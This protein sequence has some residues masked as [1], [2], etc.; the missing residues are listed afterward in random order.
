MTPDNRNPARG[1]AAGLGD[2]CLLGGERSLNSQPSR[3][4]QARISRS[5]PLRENAPKSKSRLASICSKLQ[6]D[7]AT[8]R[9]EVASLRGAVQAL[10]RPKTTTIDAEE[11]AAREVAKQ[12]RIEDREVAKREHAEAVAKQALIQPAK[13]RARA[14]WLVPAFTEA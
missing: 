12:K 11:I 1:G 9:R 3:K 5:R 7:A 4:Y 13:D 2:C 6:R 10:S 8:L 14:E